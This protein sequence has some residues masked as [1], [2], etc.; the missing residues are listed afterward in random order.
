MVIVVT[1]VRIGLNGAGLPAPVTLAVGVAAGALAY[2]GY[3]IYLDAG[4]SE[5]TQVLRDFGMPDR[6]PSHGPSMTAPLT[7]NA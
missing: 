3:V 2:G 1:L 5:L 4:L 7:G 6:A